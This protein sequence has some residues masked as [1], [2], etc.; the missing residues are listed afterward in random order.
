MEYKQEKGMG[1]R[2]GRRV[3]R[4]GGGSRGMGRTVIGVR[5]KEGG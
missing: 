2:G 4:R 3:G 1:G 5:R